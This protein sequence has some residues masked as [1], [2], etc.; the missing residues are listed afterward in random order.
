LK[1]YPNRRSEHE[2]RQ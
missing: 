1:I 2:E